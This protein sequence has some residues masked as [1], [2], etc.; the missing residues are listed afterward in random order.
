M[1]AMPEPGAPAP[2]FVLPAA[3]GSRVASADLRGKPLVLFFFPKAS[4]P[5]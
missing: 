2:E 1:S 5:G 3:D 4:T